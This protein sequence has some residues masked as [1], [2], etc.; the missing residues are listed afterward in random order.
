MLR[1]RL[2]VEV[3]LSCF[4]RVVLLSLVFNVVE[5]ATVMDPHSSG[6][7]WVA[8]PEVISGLESTWPEDWI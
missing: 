1:L 4:G 2:V 3:V 6:L 7:C 8:L 5:T